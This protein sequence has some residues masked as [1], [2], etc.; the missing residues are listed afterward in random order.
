[1]KID[2]SRKS[3]IK[4]GIYDKVN[5]CL[6]KLLPKE[7]HNTLRKLLSINPKF[8][9]GVLVMKNYML[10]QVL[11][12]GLKKKHYILFA[13]LKSNIPFYM[14]CIFYQLQK[15]DHELLVG[16]VKEDMYFKDYKLWR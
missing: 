12:I 4:T 7:H 14:E 5:N 1:M 16:T 13:K 15:A 2:D 3:S 8:F 11:S 9:N 6:S 10:W